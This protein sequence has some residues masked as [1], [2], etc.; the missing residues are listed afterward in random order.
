MSPY[1][2]TGLA[3]GLLGLSIGAG[4]GYELTANHY[5]AA[6]ATEKAAHASDI[7][8]I[9]A[10]DAKQLAAALAN[11][12][13]AEGKVAAVEQQFNDEVSKHAKD[14]LDYRAQLASGA[15]RVRVRVASCMPGSPADQSAASAGGANGTA[16]YGYLDGQVAASV[17][18]V[19]AD[20]QVEIDKL[21]G[22]QAYVK[23]LQDKGY[24]A[25]PA[26][27]K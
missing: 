18:K 13:A 12:H 6:L 5:R 10:E 9:N 11:Q 4:G 8:K 24:I 19:A 17:F 3:A 22:L 23:A 25:G 27:A 7:A 20:D 1:L 21:A 16:A 26:D 14:S 2:L 15:Q